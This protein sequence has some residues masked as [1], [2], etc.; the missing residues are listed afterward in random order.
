MVSIR[1]VPKNDGAAVRERKNVWC[2]SDASTAVDA[3][4]VNPNASHGVHENSPARSIS[5]ESHDDIVIRA[6]AY[7]FTE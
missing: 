1:T 6:N 2:G 7:S 4:F 3:G 5:S